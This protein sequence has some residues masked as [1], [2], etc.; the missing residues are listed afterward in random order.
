[1][2]NNISEEHKQQFD[3]D[4]YSLDNVIANFEAIAK[5]IDSKIAI[6]RLNDIVAKNSFRI[7]NLEKK[8][9]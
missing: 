4:I 8:N 7:S 6:K 1:M 5:R 2:K 3:E 9:S